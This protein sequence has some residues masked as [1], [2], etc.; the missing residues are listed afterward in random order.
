MKVVASILMI[1]AA[2]AVDSAEEQGDSCNTYTLKSDSDVSGDLISE[3]VAQSREE[4][5]SECSGVAACEAWSFAG[6]WSKCYLKSGFQG[7]FHNA[8][9]VAGY[10]SPPAGT[11]SNYEVQMDTDVSGKMVAEI[12]VQSKEG[13]CGHC[14]NTPTCEA[15]S[16][17]EQWSKCYLKSGFQG[18]F[19]NTGIIAGVK[20]TSVQSPA[21]VL[22]AEAVEACPFTA[23]HLNSE[24]NC[25]ACFKSPFDGDERCTCGPGAADWITKDQVV[26][27][28]VRNAEAVEACPFTAKH[29]NS[30]GNCE[31]CFKSPF[32][33]DERCTCGPG[34]ADWITK[35]QVV[36]CPVRNAEADEACPFTAKHLNSEGNCAACFK[37][38][39][40]GDERCTCGPG[41]ADWITKDQVVACPGLMLV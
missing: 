26:A 38:P 14:D 29:L 32:A 12:E 6:Q 28:P 3:V 40:A 33:G 4:C 24:G 25:E 1:T 2:Y 8:G 16:Y 35:D 36:A 9:I 30:E 15:W 37:S 21:P 39:F 20:Q 18:V 23:K 31:A 22:N 19:N 5:C 13:C 17:A 10:P 11:C 34:A 41:A 27:C 7:V